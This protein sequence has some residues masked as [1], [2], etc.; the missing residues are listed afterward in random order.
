MVGN[1]KMISPN[2]LLNP[3]QRV[4]NIETCLSCARKPVVSGSS[5]VLCVMCRIASVSCSV[6][7]YGGNGRSVVGILRTDT[8]GT[9][10][11]LFGMSPMRWGW[12]VDRQ[13]VTRG[14]AQ[15]ERCCL[16]SSIGRVRSDSARRCNSHDSHRAYID[17]LEIW[18]RRTAVGDCDQT[19]VYL[20]SMQ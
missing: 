7:I 13:M 3:L 2:V 6:A 4:I 15:S 10:L 8:R 17:T 19:F 9:Y 1:I 20:C 5:G 18:Q 12:V 16:W 11:S 14:T